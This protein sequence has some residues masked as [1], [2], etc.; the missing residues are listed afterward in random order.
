MG[1][2]T[3]FVIIFV[4][5]CGFL[6]SAGLISKRWVKESSDFV[7]AGREISTPINIVGVIAIG[8]AGTTVTL[9]P[10]FTIQYGLAGGL[11]WSMI[12]SMCGLLLFGLIYSN[13]VRRSGAQTLPEFLEMRFDGNTRSV[14]AITSVIGMCGIMANNV[15]SSVDSIAAFTG[16]NRLLITAI[17]FAVIIVFTFVS[18]LWAT[19][20]TDLFQ[21]LIGVIVVPTTFFLLAGR[22]G[23]IDVIF[24]NWGPGDFV[25][26]GFV[27]TMP[28]MKL[29]YPSVFN[30]I[31]CFAAALVWG[32]NYYWMK[33]ANCRSEKVARRSFVIAA[34][35]LAAVFM[36][37]L[38][39]I[40]GFMG[41]F[42]PEEL[43]LNG[44]T[45]AP[46]GAYG[47]VAK[48]FISLFGSLV[49][50][51]A[52]AA[53]ISTA[54][55]SALGAS[56][57]A[58][59]DIYQRLINPKADAKTSL[60]MSK[61]IMLL[62]GIVTFV[63]CQFP[64][65][66]TY[67]F[68]FANCWLVPPA[69]LLGLGVIWPKFNSRGAL[70]GAVCGMVT[71]VVFTFL[72]LTGIFDVGSYVYLATL[73]LVVTLAAAII[74][75]LL[76]QPKYYGQA[77]WERVPTAA[78][79]KNVQLND[80][81]KEI[82]SML[83]IGHCYMSDLTDALG[84]DSKTSGAAVERLDQGGYLVRAGMTGSKFYTFTITEKG[85]AALPPLSDREAQMSREYLCPLY[86]QLMK[87]VRDNPDRMGEFVQK[88][89]IKSMK[90]SAICSHLTRRGYVV[91]G[92][93]FRRKLRLT[94]KGATAVQKYS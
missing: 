63:L 32:N 82:L 60:R 62:I 76:G 6:M 68:A 15:V 17:L 89:G 22:F 21:V 80:M 47:F 4:L 69:I 86:V 2:N 85:A 39:L 78:N 45:V 24:A 3:I 74:A 87:T 59:R 31:V 41:A 40:G 84:V 29:T 9:A 58:N 14:V 38:C 48:T 88:H 65:G 66:P 56:A 72:Q 81:D 52:V 1:A 16:W 77:G 51:S 28:G 18:G 10:G 55:T 37:P 34:I 26:Q 7:L 27:G 12:Y 57:V 19:T 73:G 91:E 23:W 64:G 53:S 49:V 90:M 75:S 5:F 83:R 8:F 50:I 43:T 36:I 92:G 46:T 79:R 70:W 33:V 13:L 25:T 61:V 11:A 44:G 20:I 54:S 67:L 94:E 35:L 71:M 30:F 93:L 42:Y